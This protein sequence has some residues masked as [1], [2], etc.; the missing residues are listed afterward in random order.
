MPRLAPHSADEGGDITDLS[1]T[2]GPSWDAVARVVDQALDLD[3]AD[4]PAFVDRSCSS[5]PA[6]RQAV[7]RLLAA[8]ARPIPAS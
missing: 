6:L 7:E 8:I 1:R 3:P 4:A 5:D 2:A